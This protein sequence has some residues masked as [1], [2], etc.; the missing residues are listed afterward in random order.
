MNGHQSLDARAKALNAAV[1][2]IHAARC[3]HPVIR[4]FAS[5]KDSAILAHAALDAIAA[6][7]FVIVR[8]D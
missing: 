6:L 5:R 1:E 2:G 4:C 3:A 7:G 8:R